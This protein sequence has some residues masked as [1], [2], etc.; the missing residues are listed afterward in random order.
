MDA[1]LLHI[2]YEGG[3]LEDPSKAPPEKNLW[4]WTNSLENTPNKPQI[5]GFPSKKVISCL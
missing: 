5:I 2:S 3:I 1:N 4:K